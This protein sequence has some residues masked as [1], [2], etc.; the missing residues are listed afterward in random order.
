[1]LS[2]NEALKELI[3]K[4]VLWLIIFMFQY[5]YSEKSRMVEVRVKWNE[6]VYMGKASKGITTNTLYRNIHCISKL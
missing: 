1:M 5:T 3:Q 2:S 4:Y 6:N